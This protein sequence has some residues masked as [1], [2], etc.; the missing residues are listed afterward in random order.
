M[1]WPMPHF[2]IEIVQRPARPEDALEL[3][4]APFDT[5]KPPPLVEDDRPGPDRGEE[6]TQHHKLDDD[7]GAQEQ[8][9]ME[10]SMA[11][12]STVVSVMIWAV[13]AGS[14]QIASPC[15]QARCRE[16]HIADAASASG[17]L[18]RRALP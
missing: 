2:L 8:P 15:V 3:V 5:G 12:A 10:K 4:G 17:Q 16:R 13:V 11:A 6:K 1:L 9:H 18:A 14:I 7:V